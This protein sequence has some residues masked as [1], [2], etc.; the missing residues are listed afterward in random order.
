MTEVEPLR[1]RRESGL[2]RELALALRDD[3][4]ELPSEAELGALRA[5]LT[6]AVGEP[7]RLKE[8]MPF[9]EALT[10]S[11]GG[12][13]SSAELRA[14]RTR[15]PASSRVSGRP[16]TKRRAPK[17][18]GRVALL[19]WLLPA[20]ALAAALAYWAKREPAERA[21]L[22]PR[23]NPSAT[24][25]AAPTSSPAPLVSQAPEPLPSAAATGSAAPKVSSSTRA[26]DVDEL[27][28]LRE[29]QKALA[30]DP[31]SA[32]RLANRH[33]QRF[34]HGLLAQEREVV[35]I[36]ALTRLGRQPEARARAARFRASHPGSAYLPRIERLVPE[37][38]PASSS[39]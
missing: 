31:A 37:G 38:A 28:L 26:P 39:R 32:L 4:G 21:T 13:P 11:G 19:T 7:Q 23:S 10:A 22:T 1:L 30:S 16:V 33:A 12:A 15:L 34:S 6:A 20:A 8:S 2:S 9:R 35:A 27:G 5:Q 25:S 36:D 17:A 29:A 3:A 24:L 18:R 14:L